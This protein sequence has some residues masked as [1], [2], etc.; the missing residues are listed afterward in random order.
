MREALPF[1]VQDAR[2]RRAERAAGSQL[3]DVGLHRPSTLQAASLAFHL[4]V[5]LLYPW[6]EPGHHTRGQTI[7]TL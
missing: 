7:S 1:K 6:L 5:W 2:S 4:F 3:H